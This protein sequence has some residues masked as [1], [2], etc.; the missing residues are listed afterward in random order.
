MKKIVVFVKVQDEK[1]QETMSSGDVKLKTKVNAKHD[2][3]R[4]EKKKKKKTKNA[5]APRVTL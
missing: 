3:K 1:P 2:V 4:K 5:A